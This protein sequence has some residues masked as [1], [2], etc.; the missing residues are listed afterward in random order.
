MSYPFSAVGPVPIETQKHV[1]PACEHWTAITNTSSRRGRSAESDPP[2]RAGRP[3]P[4]STRSR[5]SIACSSQER[6]P[7]K[8]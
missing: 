8:A 1:L 4:S 5:M 6:A 3:A 2:G 7:R